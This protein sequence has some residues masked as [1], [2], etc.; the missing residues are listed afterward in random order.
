[1]LTNFSSSTVAPEIAND[2]CNR[3][4]IK[5]IRDIE[6]GDVKNLRCPQ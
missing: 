4:T 2:Q 6:N 5:K 3:V 1:M